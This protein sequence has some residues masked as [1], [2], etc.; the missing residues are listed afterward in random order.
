MRPVLSAQQMR[1]FDRRATEVLGVSGLTLMEHAGRGASEVILSWLEQGGVKPPC[2]VVAGGGNNGGDGF[3][4]ARRLLAADIEVETLLAVPA[5]KLA[6]DALTNYQALL[7]AGAKVT[8]LAGELEALQAA[9][10]RAGLVIDALFGTGLDREITGFL[11]Q[12]I[13]SINAAGCPKLAL[14]LP[15]GLH[16]DTGRVLGCCVRAARTVTF[17]HPKLGLCTPRGAAHAG[18]VDVR[19]IGVPDDPSATGWSAELVEA[20]DV[21]KYLP[22]RSAALHKSSA[23]RLLVVAGSPG[24]L[25]AALLSAHGAQRAGA[26]LVTI[27]TSP[28]AAD[29]LD[30]RVLECMTARIDLGAPEKSLERLLDPSNA[31]V[32]GPGLGLDAAARRVVEA[33]V[34]GFQG[35]KVVD[36]DAISHF[37]GR[38]EAL[39]GARN[40]VLTPHAGELGRVLG[41]SSE[42]VENDRFTA[43]ARAVELT[44]AVVLLKGRFSIVG[45]PGA[46]PVLNPTGGPVLATGGSGDVLSGIIAA[47]CGSLA[48]REAAFVGAYLH[49]AAADAWA[50]ARAA[51][52]GLLAHELADE[53]PGVIGRIQG[54]ALG[55]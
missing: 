55:R 22:P 35:P 34:L 48:P 5:A 12:V 28:A 1:A 41:I 18:Q 20:G 51:D 45:A 19:G 39:R 17:A 43:V 8:E 52:R 25:G 49:G 11:A 13:E 37:A 53:L 7:T 29:A 54:Q 36:A 38:A 16:A 46:L 23:G 15:S 21:A 26:G 14:D 2:V 6:G 47:L 10:G 44:S 9:L 4:V 27:A 42:E 24:K 32:V 31:A 30:H 33:V 3:V 40:V 50:E